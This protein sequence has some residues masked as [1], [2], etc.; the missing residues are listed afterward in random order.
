MSSISIGSL[1]TRGSLYIPSSVNE[2]NCSLSGCLFD[3]VVLQKSTKFALDHTVFEL[4]YGIKNLILYSD[5]MLI[6]KENTFTFSPGK[7]DGFG[8]FKISVPADLVDDY[9]NDPV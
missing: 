2:I 7:Y 8:L 6:I 5:S 9:T 3:E 1:M 4:F